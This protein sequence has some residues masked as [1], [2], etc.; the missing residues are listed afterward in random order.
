MPLHLPDGMVKKSQAGCISVP[1]G[2][3]AQDADSEM[4]G[5]YLKY[6]A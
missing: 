5:G 4:K 2:Q 6:N 3:D 1:S